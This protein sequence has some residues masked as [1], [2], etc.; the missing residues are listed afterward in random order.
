MKPLS[1][2]DYL[3][4]LG[5]AAGEKAPPRREGSP[6]RPRSLPSPQNREIRVEGGLRSHN[7]HRRRSRHARR[8]GSPAHAMGAKA[9]FA[10]VRRAGVAA[11]GRAGEARGYVGEA[12]RRLRPRPRGRP[13]RGAASRL[14]TATRL[15]SPLRKSRRK[16]SSRSFVS[17]NT[18]SLRARSAP[19]SRRS[20]TMSGA[21][22]PASSRRFSRSRSSNGPWTSWPRRLPGSA[23]AIRR[24]DQDSRTRARACAPAPANR[25]SA[26]RGRICRG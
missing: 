12:R 14:R 26:D 19:G 11:D 20:R 8:R 10:R 18:R 7:E 5:R 15:S 4:H 3:D 16:R 2:A 23:R 21:L 17:T 1:I 22:S 25:R 24:V 6:F 9:G 13:R